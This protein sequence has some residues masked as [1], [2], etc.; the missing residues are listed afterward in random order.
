[1][2]RKLMILYRVKPDSTPKLDKLC[3]LRHKN[4]FS[5]NDSQFFENNVFFLLK[6]EYGA[7]SE[8]GL[9]SLPTF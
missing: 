4:L 5:I 2:W 7:Y 9:L 6:L 3:I 1:M 8:A